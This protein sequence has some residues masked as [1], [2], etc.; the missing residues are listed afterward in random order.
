MKVTSLFSHQEKMTRAQGF[1]LSLIHISLRRMIQTKLEDSLAD[2]LLAG[3]VKRG[4]IVD[5]GMKKDEVTFQ[6][7]EK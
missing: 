5:V 4:D 2:E 7:R 1:T 3:N 6:V